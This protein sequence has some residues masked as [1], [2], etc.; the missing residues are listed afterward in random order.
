MLLVTLRARPVLL[1]KHVFGS[2]G[3]FLVHLRPFDL[4]EQLPSL[5]AIAK[6]RLESAVCA[7]ESVTV[8]HRPVKQAGYR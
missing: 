2:L 4:R 5:H 7:A 1:D 6:V 8:L 3:Q